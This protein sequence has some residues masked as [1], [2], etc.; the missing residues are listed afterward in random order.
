MTFPA[1]W[2]H[3]YARTDRQTPVCQLTFTPSFRGPP[4]KICY[5]PKQTP[6]PS[7][8]TRSCALL[9]KISISEKL[10]KEMRRNEEMCARQRNV[11][12]GR[13]QVCIVPP[14][15]PHLSFSSA[16]NADQGT[17]TCSVLVENIHATTPKGDTMM[18]QSVPL[19]WRMFELTD[20]RWKGNT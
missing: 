3:K 5:S 2:T 7:L 1:A 9:L 18:G 10:M 15:V 14:N 19:G 4:V 16:P 13:C 11:S 12:G 8:Y 20:F 17:G 6:T